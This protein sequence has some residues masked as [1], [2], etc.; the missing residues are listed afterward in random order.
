MSPENP[1]QRAFSLKAKATNVYATC[2]N[3]D[4]SLG[5]THENGYRDDKRMLAH[6]LVNMFVG[7]WSS[8]DRFS[9]ANFSGGLFQQYCHTGHGL[10][11]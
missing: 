9:L 11:D 1:S 6:M 4:F 8:S 3:E 10:Q 2:A 7:I 5:C